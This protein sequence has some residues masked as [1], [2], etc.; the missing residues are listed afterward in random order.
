MDGLHQVARSTGT[1]VGDAGSVLHLSRHLVHQALNGVVRG[2]GAAGHHAGAFQSTLGTTG[3]THADEAEAL[4]LE[5]FY[6]ALGVVIVRVAT[7]DEQIAFLE[8]WGD[9]INNSIHSWTCLDHHQDPART[10]QFANEILQIRRP[11]N[12]PSLS[13][14][15]EELL[16]FGVGAVVNNA[17]EPV[18]LGIEDEVL[19]HHA[20]TDQTEV[21]LGHGLGDH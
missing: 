11:L 4:A 19:P 6:P 13:A 21:R 16:S 14:T 2:F 17:R 15:V 20:E 10:L 5:L 1:D 12:V 9:L 7:I 18:A 8:V 3:H